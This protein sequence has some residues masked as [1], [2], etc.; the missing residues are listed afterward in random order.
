MRHCRKQKT[1]SCFGL[2]ILAICIFTLQSLCYESNA[3]FFLVL[4]NK[5]HKMNGRRFVFTLRGATK[6]GALWIHLTVWGQKSKIQTFNSYA[7]IPGYPA[8]YV[9]VL[10]LGHMD[11]EVLFQTKPTNK[12]CV[13]VNAWHSA[14]C[15]NG[16]IP[17]CCTFNILSHKMG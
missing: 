8:M 15:R 11:Y 3:C 7:M 2:Y 12:I 16:N 14:H 10:K 4:I 13:T 1:M 5:F 9:S 17:F 6:T